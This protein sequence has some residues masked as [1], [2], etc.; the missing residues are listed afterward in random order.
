MAFPV[1]KSKLIEVLGLG[2]GIIGF[3][4]TLGTSG[5]A[6]AAFASLTLRNIQTAT[7]PIARA[8]IAFKALFSIG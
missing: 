8:I 7:P 6:G 1:E 3:L 4:G 5:I 2:A